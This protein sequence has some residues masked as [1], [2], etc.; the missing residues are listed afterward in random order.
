MTPDERALL[1]E[2]ANFTR[3]LASDRN[4]LLVGVTAALLDLYRIGFRGGS[5]TKI[6]ALN[7]LQIQQDELTKGAAGLGVTFLKYLADT[8]AADK[9]DAA[10]LYREPA[11]GN[12]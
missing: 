10:K 4:D 2:T 3:Q 7:R 12:A 8:L 5:D 9:L 11:A 6:Q 1:L